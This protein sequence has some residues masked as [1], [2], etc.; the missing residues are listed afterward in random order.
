[1][2][3]YIQDYSTNYMKK[4]VRLDIIVFKEYSRKNHSIKYICIHIYL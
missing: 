3:V 4:G 2:F 1:M